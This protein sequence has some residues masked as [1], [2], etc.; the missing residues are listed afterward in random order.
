MSEFIKF[1]GEDAGE[2]SLDSV[3]A[4][5][6]EKMQKAVDDVS[7][8]AVRLLKENG[9]DVTNTEYLHLRNAAKEVVEQ[10]NADKIKSNVADEEFIYPKNADSETVDIWAHELYGIDMTSA[11]DLD[12][13]SFE[14]GWFYNKLF[15]LIKVKRSKCEDRGMM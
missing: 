12:D 11:Y 7:Q 4:E 13:K 8:D 2:S 14:I 1:N 15:E 3:S 9:I 5:V 6:T 10:Y